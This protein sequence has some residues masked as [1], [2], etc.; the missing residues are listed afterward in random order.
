[1]LWHKRQRKHSIVLDQ[2]IADSPK[3]ET[4]TGNGGKGKGKNF[5]PTH[6]GRYGIKSVVLPEILP[7]LL[8]CFVEEG[9]NFC[10]HSP[11]LI[12]ISET[13]QRIVFIRI[14]GI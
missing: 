13:K 10:E 11:E 6:G 8:V 3:T 9:T 5:L 4:L 7:F 2:R 1:M 12:E 14:V